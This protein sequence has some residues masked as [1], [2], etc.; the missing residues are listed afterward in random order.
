MLT[1]ISVLLS[2]NR[3]AKPNSY[4]AFSGD[5][6]TKMTSNGVEDGRS[7]KYNRLLGFKHARYSR[8]FRFAM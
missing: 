6:L 2:K 8:L 5:A 1:Y 4:E 7:S 3:A